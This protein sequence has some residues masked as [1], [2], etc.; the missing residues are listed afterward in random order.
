MQTVVDAGTR[1]RG[2]LDGAS[3]QEPS[4]RQLSHPERAN[5]FGALVVYSI[6][7]HRHRH[8]DR[9]QRHHREQRPQREVKSAVTVETAD[10]THIP[11]HT[12]FLK[13]Q[14]RIGKSGGSA[15]LC[16]GRR[17]HDNTRLEE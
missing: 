16:N 11:F 14:H 2:K 15:F 9:S 1:L 13:H 4:I 6:P 12:R 17:C 7:P 3:H 10:S 5:A 8:G